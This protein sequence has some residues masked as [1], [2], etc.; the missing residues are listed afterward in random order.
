M[1]CVRVQYFF[2]KMKGKKKKEL[3]TEKRARKAEENTLT[4]TQLLP[5]SKGHGI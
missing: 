5:E 4:N 1:Q 3:K 2:K